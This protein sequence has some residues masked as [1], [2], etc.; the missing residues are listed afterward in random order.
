MNYVTAGSLGRIST[1][2][3]QQEAVLLPEDQACLNALTKKYVTDFAPSTF[4][5]REQNKEVLDESRR[6]STCVRMYDS[7]LLQFVKDKL[8]ASVEGFKVHLARDHVTFV[9]YTA[10]GMFDW[11]QDHEQ[12][13]VN[14]R[15]HWR[16]G[17][18]LYCLVAPDEGGELII[19]KRFWYSSGK[20]V[21]YPYKE[22]GLMLFDKLNPH[23]AGKVE[24]GVKLILAVDVLYSRTTL[25]AG[26]ASQLAAALKTF[27]HGFCSSDIASMATFGDALE[28]AD[29]I[30]YGLMM[31]ENDET[32]D[33]QRAILYDGTHVYEWT[34]EE[35]YAVQGK[36]DG[37]N[38]ADYVQDVHV[39][40]EVEDL[41]MAAF[42]SDQCLPLHDETREN[43]LNAMWHCLASLPFVGK[44][45]TEYTSGVI[46]D[47][48]NEPP[49]GY[50]NCSFCHTCGIVSRTWLQKQIQEAVCTDHPLLHPQSHP[51]ARSMAALP[52]STQPLHRFAAHVTVGHSFSR[53]PSLFMWRA[54]SSWTPDYTYFVKKQ[55]KPACRTWPAG[56]TLPPG[57]ERLVPAAPARKREFWEILDVGNIHNV[58][59]R[60]IRLGKGDRW[61]TLGAKE[62]EEEDGADTVWDANGGAAIEAALHLIVVDFYLNGE[63]DECDAIDAYLYSALFRS[64][65]D[66]LPRWYT[67]DEGQAAR[68][69]ARGIHIMH[70]LFDVTHT[71]PPSVGCDLLAATLQS[72][73]GITV[74]TFTNSDSS[75]TK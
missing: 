64:R 58:Y 50:R 4:F 11:H 8:L 34:S 23:M 44:H 57:V 24:A 17:H 75:T 3:T 18:L 54:R 70:K 52:V 7:D 29:M 33:G 59:N 38:L 22:N 63:G 26:C 14:K 45:G 2:E 61:H 9:R 56:N 6:N 19:K 21:S 31:Y 51:P 40:K 62:S 69:V 20:E 5:S 28:D 15:Q 53:A 12:Y 73:C 67:V 41:Y 47:T 27:P 43:E 65:T 35:L 55:G 39:I 1:M 16:E 74:P 25:D 72:Q 10:G 46:E 60:D 30:P 42:T 49:N 37:A 71:H 66:V 68:L 13:I 32:E 36:R 48:C